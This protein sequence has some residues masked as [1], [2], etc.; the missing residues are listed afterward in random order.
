[1]V[2]ANG[3]VLNTLANRAMLVFLLLQM[4]D[5]FTTAVGLS[6]GA[7]ELNPLPASVFSWFGPAA[8]LPLV[9]MLAAGTII[10]ILVR[11][12]SR[13]PDKQLH[14][15]VVRAANVAYSFVVVQNF[16]VILSLMGVVA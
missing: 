14:W 2:Q 15:S 4:A 9:K 1:M 7:T 10:A 6:V 3:L 8:G 5:I 16:A 11:I 13:F 12:Q